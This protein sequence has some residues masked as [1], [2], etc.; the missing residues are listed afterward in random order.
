M[1]TA[2]TPCLQA[3]VGDGKVV[4]FEDISLGLGRLGREDGMVCNN[5][6]FVE[7]QIV[8]WVPLR[9]SSDE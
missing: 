9:Q 1:G 8:R 5:G 7:D 4:F 6:V 2:F 3:G